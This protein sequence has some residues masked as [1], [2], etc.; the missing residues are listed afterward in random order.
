MRAFVCLVSALL[1]FNF[2]ESFCFFGL[3]HIEN[4]FFNQSLC[5]FRSQAYWKLIFEWFFLFFW[6]QALWKTAL[7]PFFIWIYIVFQVRIVTMKSLFFVWALLKM[8][9]SM[10]V[11]VFLTSG[12]L[13]IDFWMTMCVCVFFW[14]HAYWKWIFQWECWFLLVSAIVEDGAVPFFKEFKVFLRP[15]WIFQSESL[16]FCYQAYWKLIFRWECLFFWSQALWKTVLCP[17]FIWISRIFKTRIA[18]SMNV[19]VFLVSCLLKMDVSMR[20][21]IFLVSAIVEDG[22]VPFF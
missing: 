5:F 1:K 20:L 13:K 17:F 21:L 18:F 7:C 15:E 2:N 11:F 9:F 10:R 19:F 4:W 16:F 3:R 12:L 6:P 8:H 14:S 22:A